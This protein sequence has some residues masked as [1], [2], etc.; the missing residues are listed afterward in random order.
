MN[1]G[2][3]LTDESF[4]LMNLTNSQDN[5]AWPYSRILGPIFNLLN[6]DIAQFR[7]ADLVILSVLCLFGSVITLSEARK[8]KSKNILLLPSAISLQV[9]IILFVPSVF[10]YLLVTP[11]YQWILITGSL[12]LTILL[13]GIVPRHSGRS[14]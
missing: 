2:L 10:R 9:V 12:L 5:F 6:K 11:G 1:L 8:G 3:D 4:N 14:A 13:I 7:I